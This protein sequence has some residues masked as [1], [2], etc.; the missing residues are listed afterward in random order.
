MKKLLFSTAFLVMT[1]YIASADT[2]L[3]APRC[4]DP[5]APQWQQPA[6]YQLQPTDS[7]GFF[8]VLEHCSGLHQKVAE[9]GTV[10]FQWSEKELLVHFNMQDSHL[11]VTDKAVD[12]SQVFLFGDAVELFVKHDNHPGYWEFQASINGAINALFFS[13]RGLLG[14][15]GANAR[16][17][18]SSKVTLHGDLNP[19]QH[20][21][22][23]GWEITLRIDAE[24][25]A[26]V[27]GQPWGK[28]NGWRLVSVRYN[29]SQFLP[30]RELTH[31][32]QM[33]K[34]NPHAFENSGR[35]NF[36]EK[37]ATPAHPFQ[38]VQ[39]VLFDIDNTLT[40][41]KPGFETLHGN[42]L[43]PI[44]RDMM[45][46]KGWEK[47][48]AEKAILEF[49]QRNVRWDYPD[50]FVEFK[51]DAQEAQRRCRAWHDKYLMVH[52]DAVALV[53]QLHREGKFLAIA[54]NNPSTGCY[55][56]LQRAGL[57][58]DFTSPY[59]QRV[60]GTEIVRG[61]KGDPVVWPSILARLPFPP[62]K[63]GMCGDN[64]H[65]D[66]ELPEKHGIIRRLYLKR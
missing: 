32:P 53:K 18:I 54:S 56:K 60:F 45:I 66:Y 13:S 37:P 41:Y 2:V 58:D 21:R 7:E 50:F 61:C 48:A 36:L 28:G 9:P 14:L 33:A 49:S 65:D 55:W 31:F 11:V 29:Y 23:Q 39:C 30:V 64:Y 51:L 43:F 57:A 6:A 19:P 16:D 26:K 17:I 35:I 59:F 40:Y 25:M 52:E 44:I 24:K 20:R 3:D 34:Y 38:D 22:A 42:F 47:A 62:H 4:N 5:A 8:G 46:E 12:Q 27:T 15:P 10:Q 63:I 1:A